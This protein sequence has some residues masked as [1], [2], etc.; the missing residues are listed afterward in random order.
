MTAAQA[1]P[2]HNLFDSD[3]DLRPGQV[4]VGKTNLLINLCAY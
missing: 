3:A 2:L 4:E 1:L